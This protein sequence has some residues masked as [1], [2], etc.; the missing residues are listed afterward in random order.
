MGRVGIIPT[1]PFFVMPKF[2]V[3]CPHPESHGNKPKI[4]MAVE[5][6]G[7]GK[8]GSMYVNCS[9]HGCRRWYKIDISRLGAA[10]VTEMPE[11]YHFDFENLPTLVCEY[12]K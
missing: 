12:G 5:M 1:G 3:V 10:M 7:T 9:H 8:R 4:L 2:K 11:N 6:D